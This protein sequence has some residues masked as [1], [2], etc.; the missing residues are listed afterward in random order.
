[1]VMCPEKSVLSIA[2]ENVIRAPRHFFSEKFS[3]QFSGQNTRESVAHALE[4]EPD[5]QRVLA[6]WWS[7]SCLESSRQQTRRNA[8]ILAAFF[9]ASDV[10]SM[11]DLDLRAVQ[12]YLAGLQE[13]GRSPKTLRNHWGA[14]SQ[15]CH[16]CLRRGILLDNPCQG[17]RLP[18][19]E[20]KIP[21]Y[22]RPDEVRLS[23]QIARQT[24]RYCEI[25]LAIFTGLRRS[26]LR[27]LQWADVDLTPGAATL[28]VRKSKSKKPRRVPLCRIARDALA[29]Q[30]ARFGELVY[31]FPG[32]K[33]RG[34]WC[35]PT[36][37]GNEWWS[38]DALRP[39]QEA[40]PRFAELPKGSTGRGWHLLRHTFGT[41]CV[42]AKHPVDLYQ[43]SKWIGH[44]SLKMTERYAHLAPG[45]N[46]AIERIV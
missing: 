42:Q 21:I 26:E 31:V 13:Q 40:I 15:F 37:R 27:M 5:I 18:K 43:V 12:G 25:A 14:I 7:A 38:V 3:S 6:E 19:L 36:P 41:R 35:R 1:M 23:L 32:G 11:L 28:L 16:F 46:K 44:S 4:T 8:S 24:D 33:P 34:G 20:E 45:Y 2:R 9:D 10:Q 22:L 30:Q 17:V 39:L 29:E